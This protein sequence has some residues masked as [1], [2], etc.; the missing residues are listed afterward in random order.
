MDPIGGCHPQGGR[1]GTALWTTEPRRPFARQWA[2]MMGSRET[3]PRLRA[4]STEEILDLVPHLLGF[5]PTD[6]LVVLVV[7]SG[8]VVV[9][10]RVDLAD[11]APTGQLEGLLH[12]LW[13]RFPAAGAWLLAY[14]PDSGLGWD[15]LQRCEAFLE[16]A[17]LCRLTLVSGDSWWSDG[18]GGPGGRH[19]PGHGPLAA[20]AAFHGLPARRTRAEL[21]ACFDPPGQTEYSRLLGL[22]AT[23]AA[24]LARQRKGR[25][26]G[27]LVRVVR[28]QLGNVALGE[29]AAV[30]LALLACDPPTQEAALLL[31]NRQNA[32]A[33]LALWQAV[34][35]RV[36]PEY[37]GNALAL[38]GMAGWIAGEGAV[39]TIC[40]DRLNGSRANPALPEILQLVCDDVVPPSLWEVL[41]EGLLSQTTPAV[42]RAL[43]RSPG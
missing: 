22:A 41:R 21:E 10:A 3:V 31:V 26:P 18:P 35:N 14:T 28:A 16:R 27:D 12:R 9:T 32:T 5:H 24:E 15:V 4:H 6:S 17:P 11:I 34:V 42:Q 40:L 13:T 2:D 29:T 1:T 19:D 7:E 43:S 38:A 20:A 37:A 36:P 23:V 30:R 25:W 39:V 8:V 33:H